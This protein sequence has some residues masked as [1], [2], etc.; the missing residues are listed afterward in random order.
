[1]IVFCVVSML[2]CRYRDG[3][4]LCIVFNGV[5]CVYVGRGCRVKSKTGPDRDLSFEEEKQPNIM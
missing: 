4:Y 1:M 3:V 2:F 5:G